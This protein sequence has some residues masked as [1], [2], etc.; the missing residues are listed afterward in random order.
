M[1]LLQI[2]LKSYKIQEPKKEK[3]RRKRRASTKP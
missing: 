2:R 3:R 1:I